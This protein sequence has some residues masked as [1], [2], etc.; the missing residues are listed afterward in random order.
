MIF[1]ISFQ[2]S[3]Q[4]HSR[5][6]SFFEMAATGHGAGNEPTGT[7]VRFLRM[8]KAMSEHILG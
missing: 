2:I 5:E 1:S 8:L 7:I 4:I 3:G 6:L